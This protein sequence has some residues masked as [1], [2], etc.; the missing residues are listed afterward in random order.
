MTDDE[1][2][3]EDVV[4]LIHEEVTDERVARAADVAKDGT[5]SEVMA[6]IYEEVGEQVL[7]WEDS[8]PSPDAVASKVGEVFRARVEERQD[9]NTQFGDKE[10]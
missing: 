9:K 5:V 1:E 8:E 4:E 2:L 7:D 3:P 6:K 10:A